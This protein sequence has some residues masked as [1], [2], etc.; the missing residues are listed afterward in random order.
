M[1][2]MFPL[3]NAPVEAENLTEIP[4]P[5]RT[6]HQRFLTISE[7]EPFGPVDAAKVFELEPASETLHKLTEIDDASVTD[8]VKKTSVVIGNEKQ[9]DRSLFKFTPAKSGS[10]GYRYGA[11]KRDRKRNRDIGFDRT[12]NMV[13]L[14]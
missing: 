14:V 5:Q 4:A 9:G 1:Y 11:S 12:G 2:K 6:L 3:Y 10:V 13:N 8:N 7:S